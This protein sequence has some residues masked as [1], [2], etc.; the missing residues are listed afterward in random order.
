MLRTFLTYY[1]CYRNKRLN[2]GN[3]KLATIILSMVLCIFLASTGN[4]TVLW[5]EDFDKFNQDVTCGKPGSNETQCTAPTGY[6]SWFAETKGWGGSNPS[7]I[8]GIVST[9]GR[10]GRGWRINL[11]TVCATNYENVLN[12]NKIS[13]DANPVYLR[14]YSRENHTDFRYSS[15]QKLFRLKNNSGNQIIIPEWM[16]DGYKSSFFR[17]WLSNGSIMDW[18]N[19]N[20]N[21]FK[22][23]VAPSGIKDVWMCY[24]LKMDIVNNKYELFIN[25]VS[26]GEKS[27]KKPLVTSNRVKAVTIGGN[28]NNVYCIGGTYPCW[29]PTSD[30]KTR[31]YDDIV[32]STERIGCTP[33]APPVLVT[34]VNETWYAEAKTWCDANGW[35]IVESTAVPTKITP[36][37]ETWYAE[38]K[39]WCD[40]NGWSI[41]DLRTAT[42]VNETWYAEAKTWCDNNGWVIVKP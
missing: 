24:E 31:D 27:A 10:E 18:T 33:I 11:R 29:T 30:F 3:M 41:V 13:T 26:M 20:P 39:T 14:W 37:N 9:A 35:V 15:Y 34:P 12:A 25:D 2:G 32:L 16:G 22:D 21:T 17:V 7:F 23:I 38:A 28:Q 8:N 6:T 36:V 5:Q 19:V 40:A 1:T 42:P 4:S